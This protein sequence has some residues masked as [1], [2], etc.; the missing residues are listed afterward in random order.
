MNGQGGPDTGGRRTVAAV[1]LAD[2]DAVRL[3]GRL[4]EPFWSQAI[5][6]GDFVQMDP[7]NGR[8]ATE[9]TE[10]RVVFTRD[11][12]YLGVTCYDSAPDRLVATQ[13]R[14]DEYLRSDDQFRWTIDTFLDGRTGYFFEMNPLGEMSDALMGATGQ[15]RAWDGIWNA[16]A[17]RS[18]IGWT[19]EIELPFR[20]FNFNPNS[21]TWG[22][23]FDRQVS[24]KNEHS[25]WSGWARNQGLQ[26]MTNAGLLTGIRDVTQGHGLDL[27]PYGVVLSQASP[28]R[29]QP[30][31]RSDTSAG[32]DVFYNPTPLLRAVFTVNTDFAQTEVDQRQVNLTRYSLFFPERRDFFLDGATFLDFGSDRGQTGFDFGSRNDDDQVIPFFS[33]RVGLSANATP[34]TIDFGTKVTGQAGAQDV[35]LLHVRTGGD[36]GFTSEDFTVARVKR[37]VLRQSYIG[38]LYT[39]RDPLDAGGQTRQTTGVDLSLATSRFRGSQNLELSAWALHAT[40]AD[41]TTGNSAF[42][43]DLRYPNDRWRARVQTTEVQQH[44]DPA[45]GFIRRQSYRRY[46]PWVAF[47]PRP[48]NH[49]YI[50]QFTFSG[51]VDVMTDLNNDLLNRDIEFQLFRVELHSQDRIEINTTQRRERLDA[52]FAISPGIRLPMGAVYDYTRLRIFGRTSD[53]RVLALNGRYEIGDFYSGT[54]T[55]QQV[56]LSV[57]PRPGLILYLNGEWNRVELPEGRFTTT[58]YRLIGETQFSPFVALVNDIQYDSQSAVLGWQSRFRWIIRPGNDLYVV[59]THNWV[60]QP[61]LDRFATLDRRVASKLLYTYRF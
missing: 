10:V 9:K 7:D 27:K 8:P 46:A 48:R 52:P 57:R 58:L 39:R 24:R 33:R 1:R 49:R 3:D 26:R 28:G 29:G 20:T 43:A 47:A 59:Y 16:R 15:N 51:S 18:E 38:G 19:L 41:A 54:R 40:Q 14:R 45:V 50:R 55:Q 6:A 53:R 61:L 4:D 21:D 37:R 11:A 56:N 23:N 32:L 60:E 2:G 36:N 17:R 13:L 31:T 25:L 5:P 35:G 34:Q 12:L 30:A 42:G 44:F 22:I